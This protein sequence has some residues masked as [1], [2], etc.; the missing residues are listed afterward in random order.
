MDLFL[1]IALSF[2]TLIFSVLLGAAL[3]YWLLAMT[4]L[5]DMEGFQV[6][7]LPDGDGIDVGGLSGV[8]MKAGLDGMPL[9]LILTVL[10][11]LAWLACYFTDYLLL[12]QVEGDL[13]RYLM[14]AGTVVVATLV[15]L[16]FTGLALR[17]FRGLFVKVQ[18]VDSVSLLGRAAIVRSPSVSLHTGTAELD[19]GGAGLILQVRAEPGQFE[20]GDRVVLVDY[21]DKAN[22]Y[23]VIAE[24]SPSP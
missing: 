2:P 7:A 22:T 10:G 21:N 17:P 13:L 11:F 5:V 16:P 19:D 24:S 23:R 1:H 18:A 3:V 20:R 9:A 12:R 6:T 4:G 8:L 15:A 14:G